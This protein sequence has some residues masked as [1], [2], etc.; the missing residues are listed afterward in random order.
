MFNRLSFRKVILLTGDIILLYLCLIITLFLRFGQNLSEENLVKHLIPFSFI[1]LIWI[2][3][4]F[5]FDLYELDLLQIGI[6]FAI[7]IILALVISFIVAVIFFYTIPSISPK[8][9][10][11]ILVILLMFSLF[12]WRKAFLKLF[13]SFFKKRIAIIG[14]NEVTN[15]LVLA[16]KNQPHLGYKLVE[17]IAEENIATLPEKIKQNK[18]NTLIV[19]NKYLV[20]QS[21][22]R[23]I[24]YQCLKYKINIIDVAKAYEI[25]FRKLPIDF[26]D[27]LWFLE[28]LQ[29]GKKDLYDK[30]KRITDLIL[31][32]II[33]LFSLPLW[34]IFAILIK[35]DSKGPIFYKQE[36]VGK[37]R[38]TFL[39]FKFRSMHKEAEKNGPVWAE[40]K[41]NRVTRIGKILRKIHLDELPQMI[42][43]I[44]GD[45]SL[46]GPRPERPIFV[47]QLEK[48]IPHYHLR[49]LIKPGFTGWAFIR[50]R[51][52]R[53]IEDSF[54]KFQYDLYYIKNRSL[55]LDLII[56]LRTIP[57]IFKK[58]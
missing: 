34:L 20:S 36:R 48:Q 18:V 5:L 7:R 49:H 39:L 44:K 30:M 38:K 27:Y 45:I 17:I 1:Y 54:E 24:I 29:E 37:N 25:T 35:L 15:N 10:L 53:S 46:I 23:K 14:F 47:E 8:T 33:F 19:A 21:E 22:A 11:L 58:S 50:F 32:S 9:N 57:F 3:I 51:Y 43:I 56:L 41:D 6:S 55:F 26:L 4:F 2:F 52:A 16:F 42:N 28:N 13:T 40:K 31:A 12:F